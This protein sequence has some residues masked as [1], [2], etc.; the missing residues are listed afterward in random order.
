MVLFD[1]KGNPLTYAQ[2]SNLEHSIGEEILAPTLILP[3]GATSSLGVSAVPAREDHVHS[4]LDAVNSVSGIIYRNSVMGIAHNTV[5]V[6]DFD[7]SF[8][9]LSGGMTFDDTLNA[10]VLPVAGIYHMSAWFTWDTNGTGHRQISFHLNGSYLGYNI[11]QPVSAFPTAQNL[12]FSY[13]FFA[14]GGN[15]TLRV[16]QTSGGSLNVSA[17][18]EAAVTVFSVH[19]IKRL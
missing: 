6:F 17:I 5:T 1:T 9:T 8:A 14:A 11:I 7:P 15:I 12:A 3:T 19:L 18:F 10:F 16:Y 4:S 13:P 2:H